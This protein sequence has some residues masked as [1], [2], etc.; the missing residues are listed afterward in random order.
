MERPDDELSV[1]RAEARQELE[2]LSQLSQLPAWKTFMGVLEGNR[3]QAF[4]A[5]KTAKSG[6]ELLDLRAR[7]T[8][9]DDVI[10][11]PERQAAA[12]RE[13]LKDE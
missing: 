5:F 6:D 1:A 12:L 13:F 8:A 9:L 3:N 10:S 7:W 2:E 11:W 4:A